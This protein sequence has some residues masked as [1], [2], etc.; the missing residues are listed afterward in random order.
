M[1]PKMEIIVSPAGMADL[2]TDKRAGPYHVARYEYDVLAG[3][4]KGP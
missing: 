2:D 3:E 4:E 1:T